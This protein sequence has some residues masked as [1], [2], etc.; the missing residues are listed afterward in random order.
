MYPV[1][2]PNVRLK[3]FSEYCWLYAPQLGKDN[4][5]P[6]YAAFILTLMDGRWTVD[7]LVSIVSD[8][9][10]S[11]SYICKEIVQTILRE[12]ETCIEL[13]SAPQHILLRYTPQTFLFNGSQASLKGQER[14][15]TPNILLMSL[16]KACNFR[17]IYCFNAS[18]SSYENELSGDEWCNIIEQAQQ[19]GVL[20][21][22]VTGG[23]PTIHPEFTKILHKLKTLDMDFKLFTNGGYLTDE[24]LDLLSGSSVQVSLDTAD[25]DIHKQL[26][27]ADTFNIVIGNMKRLIKCGI[28]V[29]VKSVITTL[30]V[31]GLENLYDLCNDLGV[32]LLSIDKF[33]VSS[34][35]RGELDLRISDERKELLIERLSQIQPKHTRLNINLSKDVWKNPEESIGCGAFRAS[36][37][38]SG[39]G[40]FIGC[41][42]IIDV[43]QMKIGNIREHSLAELW[44]SPK[45]DEFIHNIRN[46]TDTKCKNCSAFIK[47][48]TGCFAMKHYFNTPAFSADPRCEIE[49]K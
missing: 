36:M 39:C 34:C 31:N 7:E 25:R 42:K 28:P 8:V 32:D 10:N 38:L 23:E 19:L 1:L 20:Q 3:C 43:P 45:I 5:L 13:L 21:V 49:V 41:E 27:G 46:T 16:T 9:Y 24:I 33:D 30:N 40:D 48:R 11:E 37:I 44:N 15:E 35:G 2:K 18:G 17:C 14:L 12:Y 29:S 47:C 4:S 6:P 22:L 26:T